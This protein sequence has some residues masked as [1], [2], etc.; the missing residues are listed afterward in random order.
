[1]KS[2]P[3]IEERPEQDYVGVRAVMSMRDFAREL[4][5]MTT[6][7]SEWLAAKQ[8]RPAGKPLLRYHVIDIPDRMDVELGMPT[9]GALAARGQVQSSTLPAGRYAVLTY[10]GVKNG[11]SANKRLIEWIA[12]H[13]QEML[14]HESDKGEVFTARYETFL[15]DAAAEPDQDQW[16]VEVAIKLR[17]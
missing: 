14:S 15:T 7:V 13:D 11:V 8:L 6:T 3:T 10:R 4:P 9:R 2:E 12:A 17:D 16:D 5:S 1:M